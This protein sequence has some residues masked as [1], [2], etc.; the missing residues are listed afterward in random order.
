[1]NQE[2]YQKIREV[3]SKRQADLTVCMEQVHKSHNLSAI[4]R[5]C[6]SVGIQYAH[7]IWSDTKYIG[8]GIAAGSD[9]WMDVIP[10]NSINDAVDIFKQQKMQILVTAVSQQA[11][12]FRA[13]DYTKP[14]A[15]IMGQEK[16]G[17]TDIAL[18][19]AD[20]HVTI[21]MMG[22]V[23][24]L[25]VSVAAAIILAEAQR[26]RTDAGMYQQPTLSESECQRILFEGCYPR[27][28][29]MCKLRNLPY[30]RIDQS[31]LVDASEE[32]WQQ[33]RETI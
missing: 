32:W 1:M 27:Y 28:Q 17:A 23:Q 31:G 6:D 14:T 3:L 26:Q 22:M 2:R 15:I 16:L 33:M 10:H 12:D 13:I 4:L 30:P 9:R 19:R 24:S 7:A 8:G 21:P 18:S 29:R 11:V 25:N 20:H 5:S